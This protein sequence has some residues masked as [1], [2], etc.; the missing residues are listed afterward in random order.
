MDNSTTVQ[1]AGLLHQL[2]HKASSVV[3][4][5]DPNNE[6]T[7]LRIRTKKHEVMI[8]PGQYVELMGGYVKLFV[9]I[10]L[11]VTELDCFSL[12]V[13]RNSIRFSPV[14]HT[15]VSVRSLQYN[16][17]KLIDLIPDRDYMLIVIQS[18]NPQN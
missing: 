3:R 12:C 11:I 17:L 5:I 14:H 16:I 18:S 8:A 1:Y 2:R 15:R 6:M 9:I 7:F 10:C 4:D 13:E